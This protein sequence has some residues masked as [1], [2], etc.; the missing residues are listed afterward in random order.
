MKAMYPGIPFSP[1]ATLTDNIGAADTIIKVSDVAAFPDAPNYAT[2]GTDED[3]ETIFYTAKTTAALSGC[4]RGVEGTAKAWAAGEL[5]GRNFTAADHKAL[6]DN[7]QEAAKTAE[8]D[9]VTFADGETFQEKY[10]SGELTG[11][12][13][14]HGAQG[15]A[16]PGANEIAVTLPASGWSNGSQTVQNADLVASGYGYIV[17]AAP[18]SYE[19]YTSCMVRAG[20]VTTDGQITF[21]CGETPSADLTVSI[22]KIK[23]EG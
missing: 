19:V 9:G 4:T 23:V 18:D 22:M 6:I 2:I 14:T 21:S 7:V 20:N 15:P 12:S 3:G 8:A 16:G 1:Q 10:D 13:G 11:P 5:I 17:T